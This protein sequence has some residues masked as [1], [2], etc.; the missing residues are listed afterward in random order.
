MSVD[1]TLADILA[2]HRRRWPDNVAAIDQDGAV[3]LT[4][5]ALDDRA[6]Q[7]ANALLDSD[8]ALGSRILWLGQNSFRLLEL[9]LAAAKIGAI[10]CPV[11]WRQSPEELGFVIADADPA[12]IVWQDAEIGERVVAARGLAPA[13]NALWLRHDDH[14]EAGSEYE[15]FLGT[16]RETDATRPVDATSPLL[17]VY[18]AAFGGRPAGALITHQAIIAQSLVYAPA[19]G[20]T[21][22]YRYLNVGPLFHV[23]TLI[24]TFATFVMGGTNVFVPRNDPAENCRIIE[25]E[26]ITGAFIIGP[27][28]EQLA[29]ANAK[30]QHDLKSLI[31]A[32]GSCALNSMVTV[33]TSPWGRKPFGYGQTETLGYA[34]FSYLAG[35]GAMGRP[36]PV[37]QLRIVDEAWREV[38]E[39]E[40]G[41]VALR[42]PTVSPAYWN[43][44]EMNRE[45][46]QAGWHRTNDLGRREADG[47]LSFVGPKGQ[48]IKS[49]A[50]NIYP[51]E[52]EACIRQHPAVKDVGVIGVPDPVWS[53]HVK[54]IVVLKPGNDVAEAEII[55]HCRSRIASYKKPRFVVFAAEIPRNGPAIDY[56]RLNADHGGGGYPGG[57]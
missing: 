54:A 1:M 36:T 57:G 45:R 53:Q 10:V 33:D 16:G 48:L 6:N 21:Q 56:A 43:R 28:L 26:K 32:G 22:D 35:K 2:E 8:V 25:A 44:P 9:T 3:R 11:N 7:L 52:V 4:Y 39:G 55:E 34:T 31:A 51:A 42:G 18:T 12:V 38:A 23:A 17:M 15:V 30:R 41:E 47:T 37:V 20:I 13:P 50:E 27:A 24:D 49:A 40:V 5:P 29:D 19:R 46:K 14:G